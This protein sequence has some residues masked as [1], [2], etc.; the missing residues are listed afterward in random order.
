MRRSG[1][2]LHPTSL[3]G[4]Y[5]S[6]D[7]GEHAY[8][9]ID[10]LVT[11][12]QQLWQMLPQGGIGAGNSPYMSDSAFAGNP[13]LIDLHELQQCGWL[14]AADLV[15][16]SEFLASRVNFAVVTP[17]RMQRLERAAQHFFARLPESLPMAESFTQFCRNNAS[18]LDDYALFKSIG[19]RYPGVVWNEWP[20]ELALREPAALAEARRTLA[21]R[22]DYWCFLQWCFARQWQALRASANR[23]GVSLVG[24]VPIFVALHSADVWAHRELFQLDAGGKPT[25]VAG[26]PPDYFS[27]TGQR[28]GNPLYRWEIHARDG[29][30]WWIARMKHALAH[31]DT[32]RIDHFRGFAAYWRVP[33]DAA[34]AR[35]GEWVPGPGAALFSALRTALGSL[36]LIAEDLGLITPDV[37]E[38]REQLDLPGMVVLQ[39]AWDGDP[40]NSYLPHSHRPSSVVYTGTHDNDTTRGWWQSLDSATRQRVCDYFG[41]D[42]DSGDALLRA[43]LASVCETAILPMQDAL[44]LAAGHRM[45]TPGFDHGCWEWR[46]DW[47]QVGPDPARR[48]ADW[49]ARYGRKA[50][51]KLRGQ[52][53]HTA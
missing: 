46:F 23:S 43:A 12:G 48:L 10:W 38:L 13:L 21:S 35:T 1:V 27:S 49:C 16:S 51:V 8:H 5:G 42:G 47:S 4:P 3:P 2:L 52:D 41:S 32:I 36:P 9:F 33:N 20:V 7:L 6:G 19:E 39:F 31:F 34:D 17:W 11:A 30:S 14:D 45:N 44:G 50:A 26:V 28:W 24:D 22:I 15:P 53:G 25:A 29:Y 37:V 40:D 18:W